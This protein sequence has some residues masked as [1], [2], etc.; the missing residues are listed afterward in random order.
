VEYR[1]M[2]EQ[3]REVEQKIGQAKE[4]QEQMGTEEA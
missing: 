3:K 4:Q 1:Q 2:K